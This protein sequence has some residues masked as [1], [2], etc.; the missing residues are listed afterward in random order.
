[1]ARS[2]SVAARWKALSVKPC[3]QPAGSG[4]VASVPALRA[5]K[6]NLDAA[7][8]DRHVAVVDEVLESWKW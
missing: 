2:P 6:V 7:I 4:E 8:E 1:M 3:S 5:V